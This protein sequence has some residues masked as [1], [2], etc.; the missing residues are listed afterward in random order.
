MGDRTDLMRYV[1]AF[2]DV[3]SFMAPQLAIK[4][5]PIGAFD[6]RSYVHCRSGR[7]YSVM[8]GKIDTIFF[9][10]ERILSMIEA[11]PETTLTLDGG[12]LREEILGATR[13]LTS[14]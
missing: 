12:G 3:F 4:T 14:V 1:P 5:K 11:M 10:V 8:S 9:A 6:D 2:K 13:K 7:A